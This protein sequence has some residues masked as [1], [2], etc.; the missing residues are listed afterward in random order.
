MAGR[1]KQPVQYGKWPHIKAG[2]PEP[3]PHLETACEILHIYKDLNGS[4]SARPGGSQQLEIPLSLNSKQAACFSIPAGFSSNAGF[5]PGTWISTPAKILLSA[6]FSAIARISQS[7]CFSANA[8][9]SQ[10]ACFSANAR[11]SQSACFPANARISQSVCF[12]WRKQG[13]LN[14]PDF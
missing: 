9:I 5:S 14:P 8:S 4:S 3:S 10:S 6:C 1:Y 7:A 2:Q 13:F 12:F 11:I